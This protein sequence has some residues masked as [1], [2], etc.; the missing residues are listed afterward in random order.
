VVVLG[1]RAISRFRVPG[2]VTAAFAS[3]PTPC[4]QWFVHLVRSTEGFIV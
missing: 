3:R 2:L 1:N 4:P